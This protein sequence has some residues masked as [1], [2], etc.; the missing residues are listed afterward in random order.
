MRR[1]LTIHVYSFFLTIVFSLNTLVSFA[2]S[3][4]IEMGYNNK[5]HYTPEKNKEVHHCCIKQESDSSGNP[6]NENTGFDDCCTNSVIS[7][8]QMAKQVTLSAYD[9]ATPFFTELHYPETILLSIEKAIASVVKRTDLR[10]QQQPPPDIRV[11]IR[12]FQI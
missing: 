12:S 8:Q 4:G 7:F 5:H 2:C 1:L 3:V 6:E 10:T 11:S 9:L